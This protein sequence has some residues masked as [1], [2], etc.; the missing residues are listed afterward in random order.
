MPYPSGIVLS[1]DSGV[2]GPSA[3]RQGPN[4]ADAVFI[5]AAGMAHVS[6]LGGLT[7]DTGLIYELAQDTITAH[8]GG[9]QGSA[10]Q[11]TAQTSRVST[12]ATVG[13]SVKL[14]ASLPGLELIVIN[15]GANPMQVYGFGTDTIDGVATATGVS[16]MQNSVVLYTCVTAGAWFSEGLATG[17]AGPGL[18]TQSTTDNITAFA[19]GGQGSAVLLGSMINRVTTVA[20]AADSVKLPVAAPGMNI[21]VINAAATNSMNLFPN[22]GDAINALAANAAFAVAANK[23]VTAYCVSA[24]RWHTVLTA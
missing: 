22:T 3:A 17:F 12:V 1:E 14:P 11:L 16:Q 8:A 24:G 15:S 7:M 10:F 21:T 2:L 20:T 18:A 4:Q 19:G 9:G 5:D 13:D 23:A 6:T